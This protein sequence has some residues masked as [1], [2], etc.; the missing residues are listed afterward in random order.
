MDVSDSLRHGIIVRSYL[1]NF[2][3]SKIYDF[4]SEI[5]KSLKLLDRDDGDVFV[6]FKRKVGWQIVLSSLSGYA[7]IKSRWLSIF[8]L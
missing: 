3:S 7:I 5:A 2:H 4:V 1:E 8:Y 6:I